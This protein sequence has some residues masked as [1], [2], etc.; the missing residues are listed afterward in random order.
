MSCYVIQVTTGRELECRTWLMKTAQFEDKSLLYP[1]RKLRLRKQG[2]WFEKNEPLFPG[3]LFF[4]ADEITPDQ[5]LA[6]RQTPGI[7]SFLKMDGRPVPLSEDEE[8]QMSRFLKS[9]EIA[10]FSKVVFE[11][12][13]SIRILKGP[14]K[15]LEG[16]IVKVDRRKSRI[17]V[18]LS[19]YKEAFLIDFGFDAVENTEKSE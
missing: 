15:G 16:Q 4:I 19:L 6:V 12:D 9:G 1:R 18:S 13:R 10:G 3:Y 2:K 7:F 11:E 5:L 17:K 8:R 14:L